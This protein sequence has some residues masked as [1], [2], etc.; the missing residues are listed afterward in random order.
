MQA[1]DM[2]SLMPI[3]PD[4]VAATAAILHHTTNALRV[5]CCLRCLMHEL[6]TS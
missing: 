5:V 4:I 6:A 1:N 2:W 3:I